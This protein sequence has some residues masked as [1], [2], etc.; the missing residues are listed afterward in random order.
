M[1]WRRKCS[2]GRRFPVC[3]LSSTR[4]CS[5]LSAWTW[6]P[7]DGRRGHVSSVRL[8]ALWLHRGLPGGAGRK[9]DTAPRLVL[10]FRKRCHHVPPRCWCD[11]EV[12]PHPP[13]LPWDRRQQD[14]ERQTE[15]RDAC[16]GLSC[17]VRHWR[18]HQGPWPGMVCEQA[19]G[20]AWHGQSAA[21]GARGRRGAGPVVGPAVEAALVPG[22]C[23]RA[24]SGPLGSCPGRNG[25]DAQALEL[26]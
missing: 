4:G 14:P 18:P 12:V 10:D 11:C 25:P 5:G 7:Q 15:R 19:L 23:Q 6:P 9:R 1:H 3:L 21:V 20:T 8:P 13:L 24:H 2:A 26:L 22:L 16:L 17:D